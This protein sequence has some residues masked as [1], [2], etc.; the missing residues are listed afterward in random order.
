VFVLSI[1]EI[2]PAG[3]DHVTRGVYE[4]SEDACDYYNKVH[5]N[6][7]TIY[8]DE[9]FVLWAVVIEEGSDNDNS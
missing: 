5:A 6:A 3:N 4:S 8:G 9:P 7:H 1:I 2:D